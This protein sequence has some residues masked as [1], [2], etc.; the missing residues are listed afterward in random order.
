LNREPKQYEQ[1]TTPE[2]LIEAEELQ[3]YF[4]RD[5]E[6]GGFFLKNADE[7]FQKIRKNH[8]KL[9]EAEK[10][11]VIL[12]MTLTDIH[13]SVDYLVYAYIYFPFMSVKDLT[14]PDAK[15]VNLYEQISKTI[16]TPK[17]LDTALNRVMMIMFPS[18]TT[19][20]VSDFYE[21]NRYERGATFEE[22]IEKEG[23][24]GFKIDEETIKLTD[25]MSETITLM[26]NKIL[27]ADKKMQQTMVTFF[28][29]SRMNDDE[30]TRRHAF[31][32]VPFNT[33]SNFYESLSVTLNDEELLFRA[34]VYVLYQLDI[35]G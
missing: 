10:R 2:E 21:F 15:E 3:D 27:T 7:V 13:K 17:L 5:E 1:G 26:G 31:G 20:D 9:T 4:E 30:N 22:L 14:N 34:F 16:N 33:D 18:S 29:F 32:V 23:L 25:K 12:H 11:A 19:L 6:S 24:T 35:V 28:V 8:N